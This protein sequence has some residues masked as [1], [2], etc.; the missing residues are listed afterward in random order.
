[1]IIIITTRDTVTVIIL[2]VTIIVSMTVITIVVTVFT[3]K[4]SI[5][6]VSALSFTT[7]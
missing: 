7:K 2:P 1:M 5:Y 6:G 3:P 4:D